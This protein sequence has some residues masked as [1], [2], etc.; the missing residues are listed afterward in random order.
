MIVIGGKSHGRDVFIFPDGAV[1]KR[2]GGFWMFGNHTITR[3][4]IAEL[5]RSNPEVVVV[6]TGTSAKARIAD[7]AGLLAREAKIELIALPSQQAT[8]VFNQLESEGK[9][10]AALIH[11]TC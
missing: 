11:I 1:K 2:K 4:E 5:L 6:G 8:K 10:V 9:R 7:N 3:E